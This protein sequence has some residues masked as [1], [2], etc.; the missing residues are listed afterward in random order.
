ML[1]RV[2]PGTGAER[3]A[4]RVFERGLDSSQQ[5]TK[6]SPLAKPRMRYLEV[7]VDKTNGTG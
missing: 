6:K 7:I 4:L 2:T 3:P 5:C 1:L